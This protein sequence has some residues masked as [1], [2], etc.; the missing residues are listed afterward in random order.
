MKHLIIVAVALA[1][2]PAWAGGPTVVRPLPGY[3]CSRLAVTERQAL[4]PHGTGIWILAAPRADA[5]Q[6]TAAA[7][8]VFKRN[9][10][11]VV[12]GFA[13]VLQITGRPGWIAVDKIQPYERTLPCVPS[14]M[15]NGLVGAAP[16]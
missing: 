3:I 9:P 14:L 5:P 11:H 10:A 12:D 4:D 15:S 1:N 2:V 7:S 8:V 16:G 13:E 6:E